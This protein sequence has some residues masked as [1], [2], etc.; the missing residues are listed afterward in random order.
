MPEP[1][2]ERAEKIYYGALKVKSPA[3]RRSFLDRACQD[4]AEL[5]SLVDK[6][7]ASHEDVERF[8][9]EGGIAR[10]PVEELSRTLKEIPAPQ[11]PI[12]PD[13]DDKSAGKSII[14]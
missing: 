9:R 4:D 8:F 7:I 13:S 5:R 2:T 10:L 14:P 6:L 1:L 11:E 3:E 12:K